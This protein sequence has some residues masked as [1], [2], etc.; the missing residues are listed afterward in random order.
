MSSEQVVQDFI[1]AYNAHDFDRLT[2]LLAVNFFF[3]PEGDVV[4]PAPAYI[5]ASA[6]LTTGFPDF[7]LTVAHSQVKDDQVIVLMKD[8]EATHTGR[9]A[10]PVPHYPVVQATGNRVHFKGFNWIFTLRDNKIAE[11][12]LDMPPDAG[13]DNVLKQLGVQPPR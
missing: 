12:R 5:T 7:T 1:S 10:Y 9:F 3:S 4:L 13:M 6:A 11:L 2:S 8:S